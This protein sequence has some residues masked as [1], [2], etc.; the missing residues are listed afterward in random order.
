MMEE[1]RREAG[2]GPNP[3]LYTAR[4]RFVNE[5]KRYLLSHFMV[6]S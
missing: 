6:S 1:V 2:K 4:V 3:Y 5:T